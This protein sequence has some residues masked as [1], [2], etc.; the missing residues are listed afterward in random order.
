MS[1]AFKRLW[2]ST[3]LAQRLT[4]G[5]ILVAYVAV[6]GVGLACTEP[7]IGDEVTHYYMLLTQAKR[8]P[9]PTVTAEIPLA[10]GDIEKRTYPHVFFWHYAGAALVK[11]FG[12]SFVLVQVYHSLFWLQFL[13][14]AWLLVRKEPGQSEWSTLA[15]MAVL[16]S[17]PMSLLFSVAFYQ[18]IPAIAQILTSFLF[19]RRRKLWH[20]ILFM[21][22]ALNLKET[23]F[24]LVPVYMLCIILFFRKTESQ[25][26]TWL[27]VLAAGVIILSLTVSM[28]V[29]FKAQL[30]EAYY[31]R[32]IFE[33]VLD[34]V[35]TREP[36]PAAQKP[37]K[38]A[39]VKPA[40]PAAKAVRSNQPPVVRVDRPKIANSPGDLRNPVNY[41]VYGGGLLWLV[42]LAGG[43][44]LVISW[45]QVLAPGNSWWLI[46]G[47]W[48]LAGT[49]W[50]M[51]TAP[52]ARFF[53]PSM[54]FLVPPL[55]CA[56]KPLHRSRVLVALV[57]VLALA[58]GTTV[59]AKT[60]QI[61]H[62]PKGV[63]GAV[64]FL[65]G[66]PLPGAKDKVFMYPEGNYRLFPCN[67]EWYFAWRLKEFWKADNDGR[68]R[69]L[70]DFGVSAIVIKKYR[71]GPIDPQMNDLG[72]Y[73]DF[74]VRDI[75]K[76]K[77]FTKVYDN[78]DVTIYL[79]PLPHDGEDQKQAPPP[80]N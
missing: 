60:W 53:L 63:I 5:V 48:S 15:V 72:I 18:D 46:A 68:I 47:I 79:V 35:R 51:H 43:I 80:A 17:L 3:S 55:V 76:D 19:L 70:H 49:A 27:R 42:V 12:A 20:S 40:K 23:T 8:L 33:Q 59:L 14:V 73:P 67:H 52:D 66:H 16:A 54:V 24:V 30:R 2:S 34:L 6:L 74:F 64:R 65:E 69:M 58:Q 22:L 4:V 13:V 26:M 78:P 44:G 39:V 62:V 31:P 9:V 1:E 38:P 77:R 29:L 10:G 36:L 61:R 32:Q 28:A 41:V 7:M 57:L 21:C 11:A 75:E 56:I 50:V 37:A 25:W 45:R 71:V